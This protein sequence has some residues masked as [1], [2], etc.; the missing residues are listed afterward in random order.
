MKQIVQ[1][2]RSGEL[3]IWD[4][5]APAPRA[6]SV[7]VAVARSLISAG[8]E[9]M[10][11][12]LARSSLVGKAVSRPDLVRQLIDKTK[13]D[14]LMPTLEKAFNK[15]DN[16][17]ALG[18]SVSGRV[19]SVGAGVTH[20]RIGERVACAGA[21]YAS[22]AEL[23]SVP[24]NLVVPVAD[25]VDEDEA[26][27]VTL[28]AIALQGVRQAAPTLGEYFVVF[29]LGLL[30]QITAQIL[31]ANG[32]RV[33]GVDPDARKVEM[34]KSLGIEATTGTDLVA[35]ANALTGSRGVDGAIITASTKSSDP[36]NAAA[37]LCRQK[38]R[39]VVVGLVGM[40][41]KRDAFYKK[42]IDLRLSMS[43]GPGRYD[44]AYEEGGQDYPYGYVRWTEQR[45]MQAFLDLCAD[46]KITLKSLITHRYDI[47][48]AERA[49]ALMDGSEPYLG[50]VLA[51]P[52]TASLDRRTVA[53][54]PLSAASGQSAAAR[55]STDQAG[56]VAFIGAG[57]Y[58]KSVLIPAFKATT[59]VTLASVATNTG[60][61]ATH[62]ATKHS[63]DEAGTDPRAI[64]AD[65][66]IGTVVIATRHASHADLVVEALDAGKHV[67]CE[68]PLAVSAE[69]LQLVAAAHSRASTQLCVGF[70]RRFSPFVVE[71]MAALKGRSQPVVMMY[72]VNAGAIPGD[73]W[74]Q[75]AEGGGRIIGEICHFIDT[76]AAVCGA[77]PERVQAM[78]AKGHPDAV[79]LQIAF[80]DGSIGTVV[81]TSLGDPSLPK[82]YFEIWTDRMAITIDDY[83]S[84]SIT[85]NGR[86]TSK[87]LSRQDKGQTALVQAFM[88]SVVKP[89]APPA[90]DFE[91]L[92]TVT[93]ATF[94]AIASLQGHGYDDG[95][96]S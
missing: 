95:A 8:T 38:G 7:I 27:F 48:E 87:K 66:T 40:D 34:V 85:R 92:A 62:T 94:A 16:P 19:V 23:V 51:Y 44:A 59:G 69:Q 14:G 15:L 75:G 30:G 10:V 72:R 12:D 67:F 96:S 6:G 86:T 47:G 56:R 24:K 73:N 81:Y 54:T 91:S 37:E 2:Y 90:I 39:V 5:P 82:E 33:L 89:G 88:A 18:Y 74:V 53:L 41:L 43:Y 55:A 17:V 80:G 50:I 79:T 1:N 25:A 42:E 93:W 83:R 84:L 4:V 63:F 11:V 65:P 36:V 71:A 76:M 35:R 57:N 3:K 45:N 21:G 49:Y 64:F 58:A 61:S 78:S 32:C 29:G 22:H 20:V 28:G 31:R 26:C 60:L 70:N 52:E 77:L 46:R 9:K 68:K 13:R